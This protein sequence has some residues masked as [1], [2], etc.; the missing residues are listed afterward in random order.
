MKNRIHKLI[1]I[2]IMVSCCISWNTAWGQWTLTGSINGG[3]GWMGLCNIDKAY[4]ESLLQSYST[5]QYSS[6]SECMNAIQ[7]IRNGISSDCKNN[8]QVNC[9]CIGSNPSSN[10]SSNSQDE[11]TGYSTPDLIGTN[12]G[13]P[14]V[15]FHPIHETE[16]YMNQ[17]S[18]EY[19]WLYSRDFNGI[20]AT[21][22][23]KF[24]D[25]RLKLYEESNRYF[26]PEWQPRG[27]D[28]IEPQPLPLPNTI[29]TYRSKQELDKLLKELVKLELFCKFP[30]YLNSED[31][32]D[33]I[34]TLKQEY[35]D[36]FKELAELLKEQYLEELNKYKEE[37]EEAIKSL[38]DCTYEVCRTTM[39]KKIDELEQKIK[40]IEDIDKRVKL[41][42]EREIERQLAI[43]SKE[44]DKSYA[45][46]MCDIAIEMIENGDVRGYELYAQNIPFVAGENAYNYAKDFV[47]ENKETLIDIGEFVVQTG[48]TATGIALAPETGGASLLVADVV[49][50][51][52]SVGFNRLK[53]Q[54]KFEA[55]VN[56]FQSFVT[57]KALGKIPVPLTKGK[58]SLENIKDGGG[59]AIN[60]LGLNY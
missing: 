10:P 54:E 39:Q 11:V 59:A 1:V 16:E 52:T 7:R 25:A 43:S 30:Q 47:Q 8:I 38:N 42:I 27:F 29:S 56:A 57:A 18:T 55:N 20:N 9:Q 44:N 13:K 32:Q 24:D 40:D 17:V 26:N 5:K 4:A 6:Q 14:F 33:R 12:T 58:V 53:G 36:E 21:G 35:E 41:E 37:L 50:Y 60:I 45:V 31:Y 51:A 23:G 15:T 3:G 22:D 34:T 49:G 48:I 2:A 19:N 28:K 46:K